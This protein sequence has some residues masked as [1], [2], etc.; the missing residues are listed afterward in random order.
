M[1]LNEYYVWTSF[2]KNKG[3]LKIFVMKGCTGSDK[4][5][6]KHSVSD[7]QLHGFELHAFPEPQIL[8]P[9]NSYNINT[10]LS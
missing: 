10:Y 3:R 5:Q 2:H 9:H 8:C 7:I 6:S 1:L 4:I